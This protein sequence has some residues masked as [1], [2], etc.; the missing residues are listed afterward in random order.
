VSFNAPEA[1]AT[2]PVQSTGAASVPVRI[3]AGQS[4]AFELMAPITS[5]TAASGDPFSGRLMAPL[6]DE[7]HRTVAR[8]G[9]L[10]KGRLLRVEGHHLAP[11]F[12]IIVLQIENTQVAGS[13]IALA[14]VRDWS[15]DLVRNQ[16]TKT[17]IE[18]PLPLRSEKDAGVFRFP[19]DQ[20]VVPRGYRSDWRTIDAGLR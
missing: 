6:R 8:A 12:T 9:S 18:I 5:L 3:P 19:E 14:A 13:E 17:H 7:R 1:G 15:R 11:A 2:R 10:V 16:R 20:A 4:F